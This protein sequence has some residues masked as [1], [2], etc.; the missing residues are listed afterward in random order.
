MAP[1]GKRKSFTQ[2]SHP[3]NE[4]KEVRRRNRLSKPLTNKSSTAVNHEATSQSRSQDATPTESV[5]SVPLSPHPYNP[6]LRH[7]IKSDVFSDDTPASQQASKSTAS[8]SVAQISTHFDIASLPQGDAQEALIVSLKPRKSKSIILR[9]ISAR[10][11]SNLSQ[12]ASKETINLAKDDL[13]KSGTPSSSADC[14]VVHPGGPPPTRRS[15]FTP[16]TATRK[17]SAKEMQDVP[18][19]RQSIIREVEE[20]SL[21]DADDLEWRRPPAP[22]TGERAGTPAELGYSHLGGFR[23]GSLQV[24]NGRASPAPSEMSKIS[25]HLLLIPKRPRDISSDYGDADDQIPQAFVEYPLQ[26]QPMADPA[27]PLNKTHA[28]AAETNW[29]ELDPRTKIP[30]DLE[31]DQASQIAKEYMSELP[32]SPFSDAGTGSLFGSIRRHSSYDSLQKSPSLRSHRRSPSSDSYRGRETSS[33][34]SLGRS[35]SAS[36]VIHKPN[37]SLGMAVEGV[38]EKQL[39]GENQAHQP[40]VVLYPLTHACFQ[41]QDSLEPVVNIAVPTN[42]DGPEARRLMQKSDSGY[43]S[44]YS[45]QA[46]Q[47]D[48]RPLPSLTPTVKVDQPDTEETQF[49]QTSLAPTTQLQQRSSILKKRN[50]LSA[51][52]TFDDLHQ[53]VRPPKSLSPVPDPVAIQVAPVKTRRRLQKK[54]PQSQPPPKISVTRV[55]S[56]EGDSVPAIPF[57]VQEN[58]RIRAQEV[59]ELNQ[60]YSR[61]DKQASN[62]TMNF[63]IKDIRFPSPEPEFSVEPKRSRSR[64]RPRSWIGK[65]R[66]E[67]FKSKPKPAELTPANAMA[68]INDF[69]T[70]VNSLGSSPYDLAHENLPFRQTTNPHSVSTAVPRP[71][72]MMDDNT[73]LQFLQSRRRSMQEHER[74]HSRKGSFNDRGGIPGKNLRP[75]SLVIDAPPITP[76]MLQTVYRTSSLQGPS[77]AAADAEAPPPPPHS[78]NPAYIHYQE[79][80]SPSVR[81]SIAAGS[82]PPPDYSPPPIPPDDCPPPPPSH[83]PRPRDI[84]MDPWSAQAAAWKARRRSA[85]LALT[86][87]SSQPSDADARRHSK[88]EPLYPDI[89]HRIQPHV[90]DT[91]YT[92]PSEAY[93]PTYARNYEEYHHVRRQ[94]IEYTSRLLSQGSYNGLP[95]TDSDNHGR[96]ASS[97]REVSP[98]HGPNFEHGQIH[99]NTMRNT[100][101]MV[102]AGS[103]QQP[104]SLVRSSHCQVPHVSED[105]HPPQVDQPYSRGTSHG[106][107]TASGLRSSGRTS[108]ANA[109]TMI[110][111]K[112]LPIRPS[113]GAGSGNLLI[114]RMVRA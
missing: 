20:R 32:V 56:V 3:Q 5:Q 59:P 70:V 54:R 9:R 98:N 90:L 47:E 19:K 1:F 37:L 13:P 73:A 93:D 48:P 57:H 46:F 91:S 86:A 52:P 42:L 27:E 16:G 76:E 10:N 65:S 92:V 94:H 7:Q 49:P 4:V 77:S 89:P 26:N 30:L 40:P 53:V 22:R 110:P 83:S 101:N 6:A 24:M 96:H 38:E 68:I 108:L 50:T 44:N 15:S 80:Y 72:S 36:S 11:A 82:G 79:D 66:D 107:E 28:Q 71:R 85:G 41:K 8:L 58:L 109:T 95:Q 74:A 55:S 67:S 39:H 69:G 99:E 23:V 84:S 60:T 2:P 78:P 113:Y 29:D 87:Y 111:R 103:S 45:V 104:Y 102:Q 51:L 81:S 17:A 88:G 43:S 106:S 75:A 12:T 64:S 31:D 97:K 105:L 63:V 114:G 14:I 34:S 18:T 35:T 33:I 112:P 25:R 100:G 21:V 61:L 62:S